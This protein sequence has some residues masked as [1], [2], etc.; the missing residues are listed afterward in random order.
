MLHIIA[1]CISDVSSVLLRI[2]I[3]IAAH[4][5]MDLHGP[6]L[7]CGGVK[8][9]VRDVSCRG[10][11]RTRP[12]AESLSDVS[13]ECW[14]DGSAGSRPPSPPMDPSDPPTPHQHRPH[15]KQTVNHEN[16]SITLHPRHLDG[17]SFNN[18]RIRTHQSSYLIITHY[19]NISTCRISA[20]R[21]QLPN[22]GTRPSLHRRRVRHT[23]VR[24][25]P[26]DTRQVCR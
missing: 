18:R 12:F 20:H 23:T 2:D 19:R 15:T 3:A 1:S 6:W 11:R 21:L 24:L 4:H 14:T 8:Q 22:A 25:F 16:E 9:G 26:R 5:G 7:H 13:T 10:D 17:P